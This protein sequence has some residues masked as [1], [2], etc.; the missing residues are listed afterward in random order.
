MIY[1]VIIPMTCKN[2]LV[3]IGHDGVERKGKGAE[4]SRGPPEEGDL[5]IAAHLVRSRGPQ[6]QPLPFARLWSEL[7]ISF[8]AGM[9]TTAHTVTWALCAPF[10]LFR[11]LPCPARQGG[12]GNDGNYPI[13]SHCLVCLCILLNYNQYRVRYL[14]NFFLYQQGQQ[15]ERR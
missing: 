8:M 4:G 6:G 10:P 14:F 12:R 13:F 7:S 15:V 9:E 5:S 1:V 3:G 2:S 11:P